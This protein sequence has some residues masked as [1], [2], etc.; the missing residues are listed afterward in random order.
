MFRV[1]PRIRTHLIRA[2]TLRQ[3]ARSQQYSLLGLHAHDL[4]VILRKE[5]G[6]NEIDNRA[7]ILLPT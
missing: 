6:I 4:T 7:G 2:N 3:E 5:F 1:Q